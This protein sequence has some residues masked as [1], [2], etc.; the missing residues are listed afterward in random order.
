M[1]VTMLAV[2]S[3]T[4]EKKRGGKG[5]LPPRQLIGMLREPLTHVKME[6]HGLQP[7]TQGFTY[8]LTIGGH[9]LFTEL[10]SVWSIGLRFHVPL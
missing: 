1:V 7:E 2:R 6:R 4:A 3:Y 10:Y 8:G 9:L 5:W